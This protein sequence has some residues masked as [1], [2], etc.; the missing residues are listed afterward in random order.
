[1]SKYICTLVRWRKGNYSNLTSIIRTWQVH[2]ISPPDPPRKPQYASAGK[3]TTCDHLPSSTSLL[4][5][6]HSRKDF[7]SLRFLLL[8]LHCMHDVATARSRSID[9]LDASV[10][11]GACSL[12]RMRSLVP[13]CPIQDVIRLQNQRPWPRNKSRI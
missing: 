1:M 7:S 5:K 2:I 4:F 3:Q 11:G 12:E 8:L 9:I 13:N 10:W 6:L